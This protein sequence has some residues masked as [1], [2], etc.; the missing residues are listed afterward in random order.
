MTN[1]TAGCVSVQDYYRWPRTA[2]VAT[3][4][5][6]DGAAGQHSVAN[7]YTV[8]VLIGTGCALQHSD[9]GDLTH[10]LLDVTYAPFHAAVQQ[11]ERHGFEHVRFPLLPS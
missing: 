3:A 4:A 8:A 1:S 6:P 5:H 2:A 9:T 10:D 7:N 11:V